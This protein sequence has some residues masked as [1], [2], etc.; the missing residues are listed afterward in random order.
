ML[1][2]PFYFINII[3][4]LRSDSSLLVINTLFTIKT[5]SSTSV[6]LGDFKL[7]FFN[8]AFTLY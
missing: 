6:D 7:Y 2:I 4:Y 1:L 3:I 5:S 8:I